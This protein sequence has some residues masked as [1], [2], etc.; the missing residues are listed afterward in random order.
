MKTGETTGQTPAPIYT[1]VDYDNSFNPSRDNK[2]YEPSYKAR[3]N[4]PSWVV[5]TKTNVEFDID[6]V[7]SA[8][9]QEFFKTNEDNLNVETEIIRVWYATPTGTG[10][11]T[12]PAKKA[13][14]LM[15]MNPLDGEAGQPMKATGTLSMQ[16]QEWTEGTATITFVQGVP[17][18][19]FT[20][21]V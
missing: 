16:D 13:A 3:Q 5:S 21:T 7:D 17:T 10:T 6:I 18:V 15:N 9:L 11:V 1:F 14:F 20:P 8:A 2:T 12:Y 4:Q 19:S